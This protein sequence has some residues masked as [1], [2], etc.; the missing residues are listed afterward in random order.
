MEFKSL[1]NIESSFR[2]M[3]LFLLIFLVLCAIV[4]VY[5]LWSSYR[6][7]ERQREKIY[8]L[9]NGRSLMVALSQDLSQNRPV[10]AREHVRRFH[11]LFFTLSPD[12]AAI[13]SNIDRALLLADQSVVTY[14]N[15]LAE[16]GYYNRIIAASIIQMVEVDSVAVDTNV[17]PYDVKTY[18][19]Q[20]IVRETTVTERSLV[21]T[22]RLLN[23]TRSDDNPQGFLIEHFTVIEN[24]DLR[25]YER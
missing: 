3:R 1:K 5:A 10:E 14:F 4:S 22:C 25:T 19:R 9:D 12:K 24:N 11:A 7:A 17:Y 20:K 16:R 13:E 2:Q 8:V 18:A 6:F 15:T 23:T 21:T